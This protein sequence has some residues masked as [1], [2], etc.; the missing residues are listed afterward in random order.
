M[1]KRS[2]GTGRVRDLV[3]R[4]GDA[5]IQVDE[6]RVVASVDRE[7]FRWCR[8]SRCRR[9]QR[10]WS[11]PGAEDRLQLR[12]GSRFRPVFKAASTRRS[13]A[14][15]TVTPVAT[16][17]WKPLCVDGDGVGA[18]GQF[19]H[20]IAAVGAGFGGALQARASVLHG[21]LG[22]GDHGA[23]GV[24]DGPEDGSAEGL[25]RK[26]GGGQKNKHQDAYALSCDSP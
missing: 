22:A 2:V 16:K 12:P 19:G 26:A 11:R 21:H 25:R 17:V 24:G 3:G 13:V 20:R 4:A 14:T 5:G 10:R 8:R 23:G 7:G 6:F 1:E 18:D 15:S 9:V